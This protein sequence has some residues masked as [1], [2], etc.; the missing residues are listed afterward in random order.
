M[1]RAVHI[2]S[3]LHIVFRDNLVARGFE[4]FFENLI[5][6]KSDQH[7][8]TRFDIGAGIRRHRYRS[9]RYGNTV[10]F[11]AKQRIYSCIRWRLS[12]AKRSSFE[13]R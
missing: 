11:G 3:L 4:T 7:N 1:I 2:R 6:V 8:F 9:N 12:A 13:A 5:V 10:F